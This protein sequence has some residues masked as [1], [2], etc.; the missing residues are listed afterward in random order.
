MQ[1]QSATSRTERQLPGYVEKAVLWIADKVM[2]VIRPLLEW[3]GFHAHSS[4]VASMSPPRPR[5]RAFKKKLMDALKQGIVTP[6]R[7]LWHFE[8]IVAAEEKERIYEFLGRRSPPGFV[9]K[10]YNLFPR[11]AK[12]AALRYREI[13]KLEAKKDPYLVADFLYKALGRV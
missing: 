2:Q 6:S 5:Q 3:L 4:T 9:D 11:D 7:V 1:V 10:I 8:K 12:K 13:G